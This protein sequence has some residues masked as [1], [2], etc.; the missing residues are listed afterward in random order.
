MVFSTP[1]VSLWCTYVFLWVCACIQER[2]RAE[3]QG[4]C[5]VSFS[6]SNLCFESASLTEA[7]THHLSARL[8]GQWTP[9]EPFSLPPQ[10]Y[11]VLIAED[12]IQVPM[13]AQTHIKWV[14][15]FWCLNFSSKINLP[16][17]WYVFHLVSLYALYGFKFCQE[18]AKETYALSPL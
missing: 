9:R 11:S 2:V 4:Q 15:Y 17:L 1:H 13:L 5:Q 7:G 6:I 12:Q 18:V 16:S 10:C 8:V 14:I 3:A